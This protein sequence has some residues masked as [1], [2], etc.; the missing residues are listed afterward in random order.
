[1]SKFSPI[2]TLTFRLLTT[3]PRPSCSS[4]KIFSFSIWRPPTATLFP[5]TTLFRSACTGT[6][7]AAR[8]LPDGRQLLNIEARGVRDFDVQELD[9]KSTG[10]DSSDVAI[11]YPVFC[12]EEKIVEGVFCG[13]HG[14]VGCVV[15]LVEPRRA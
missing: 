11:S 15:G 10:L 7:V 14:G 4:K 1:S 13:G 8:R 12:L 2:S 3:S 5:Y 9:R 6:V